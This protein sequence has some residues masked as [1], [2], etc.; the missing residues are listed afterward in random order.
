MSHPAISKAK[1]LGRAAH[2][3]GWKGS[4][5]HDP[6]TLTTEFVAERNDEHLYVKWVDN[7]MDKAEY[8]ILG[9]RVQLACA[10][11]VLKILRGWPD[12]I[13]LLKLAR[14]ENVSGPYIVE[15]YR[16][17]PFDWENDS[18]EDIMAAMVERKVYWYNRIDCKVTSDF[19]TRPRRKSQIFEIRQVGPHRKIFHFV[20]TQCGMRSVLLDMVLKVE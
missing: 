1:Q 5:E 12:I 20:G 3:N 9:K 19:V 4:I 7:T 2:H 10:K 11:D 8:Y 16:R 18:D 15:T 17:L 13:A 14:A 6:S